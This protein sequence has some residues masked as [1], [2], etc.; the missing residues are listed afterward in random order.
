MWCNKILG[1]VTLGHYFS[2][3]AS[4]DALVNK[5]SIVELR[6]SKKLTD[7]LW[8]IPQSSDSSVLGHLNVSSY[9]FFFFFQKRAIDK[10]SFRET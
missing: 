8:S 7:I 1:H 6:A 5:L 10:E 2:L 4:E 9:D 3:S